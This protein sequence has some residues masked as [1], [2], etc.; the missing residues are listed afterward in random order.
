MVFWK[1]NKYN[2]I[3]YPNL[4]S[5]IRLVIHNASLPIPISPQ[6]DLNFDEKM[7]YDQDSFDHDDECPGDANYTADQN[8]SSPRTFS[9]D[10]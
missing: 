3:I 4:N 7:E 9:Q 10:E 2:N 6:E 5:A 1:K 8:T